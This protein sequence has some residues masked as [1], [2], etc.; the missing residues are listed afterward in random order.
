M[1]QTVRIILIPVFNK[2]SLKNSNCLQLTKKRVSRVMYLKSV[3]LIN[4]R[5][6]SSSGIK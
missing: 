6:L 5:V 4:A 1:S 2:S 3:P